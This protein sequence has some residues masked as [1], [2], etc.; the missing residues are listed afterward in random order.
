MKNSTCN[1]VI[2]SLALLCALPLIT[3]A[4]PYA[5][6]VS[7]SAGTVTFHLN[8]AADSVKVVFSGPSSTLDLGALARGSYN[9]PRG[10]AASYQ[11]EVTKSAPPLWTQ[12]SDDTNVLVQFY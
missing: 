1:R 12:I 11:I 6:T 8:E 7:E 10:T 9:F 3:R 5:S 2:W 4:V